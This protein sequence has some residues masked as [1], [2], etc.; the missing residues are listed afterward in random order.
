MTIRSCL[1]LLE[2]AIIAIVKAITTQA[3]AKSEFDRLSETM[4]LL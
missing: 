4:L 3:T 1:E 2:I